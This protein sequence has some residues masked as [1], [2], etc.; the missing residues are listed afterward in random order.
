MKVSS[1]K[2]LLRKETSQKLN[3]L[4]SYFSSIIERK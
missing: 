2:S 1:D 3:L 4:F